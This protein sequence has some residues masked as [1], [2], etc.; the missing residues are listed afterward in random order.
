MESGP[1]SAVPAPQARREIHG[2]VNE[3]AA[4]LDPVAGQRALDAPLR[5]G[6]RALHLH[7]L[8]HEVSGLD[9]D[10]DQCRALQSQARRDRYLLDETSA[11]NILLG[12]NPIICVA[13]KRRF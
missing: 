13:P 2:K 9:I 5:L 7:E 8:R 4:N 6:A 10:L 3:L 12:G 1:S 11:A